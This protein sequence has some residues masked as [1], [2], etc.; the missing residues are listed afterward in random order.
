MLEAWR[1]AALEASLKRAGNEGAAAGDLGVED[2]KFVA[3]E[4]SPIGVFTD[5]KDIFNVKQGEVIQGKFIVAQLGFES[6]EIQ[7]VDFPNWPPQRLP[8]GR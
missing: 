3:P 1:M 7:F 5:G 4:D 8:V 6:V 2:L